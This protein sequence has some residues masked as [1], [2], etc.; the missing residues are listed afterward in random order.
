M[1]DNREAAMTER[2]LSDAEIGEC[3]QQAGTEPFA[4]TLNPFARAV[5]AAVLAKM[6]DE[7]NWKLFSTDVCQLVTEREARERERVAFHNG[8]VWDRSQN[9]FTVGAFAR[10]RAKPLDELYPLPTI[11]RPR[12]VTLSDGTTAWQ[13]DGR[14]RCNPAKPIEVAGPFAGMAAY[15]LWDRMT[16]ADARLLADLVERPTEEVRRDR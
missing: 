13:E 7:R 3:W 2:I 16:P 12:T 9:T 14:L 15:A 10:P 4:H 6:K 8:A 11:T 5:E 1:T